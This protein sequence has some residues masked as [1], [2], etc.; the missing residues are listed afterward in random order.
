M[1]DTEDQDQKTELPT[2]RKLEKAIEQGDVAKSQEVTSFF[3]LGAAIIAVSMSMPSTLTSLTMRM[4][5]LI[6]NSHAISIN[7]GG[8]KA[9]A[10]FSLGTIAIVLMVPFL[11]GMLAGIAG[12]MIQ[13]RPVLSSKGLM[14]KLSR[15]SPQSGF[16]RMFGKEAL[17]NFVKGLVKILL[18]GGVVASILWPYRGYFE[19]FVQSDPALT[20]PASYAMIHKILIIVLA[21]MFVIAAADYLYQ[22]HSWMQ[23]QMMT[24][25][26]IKEEYKEQEGNPEIKQK[27]AQMRRQMS[28][29]RMMS[30]VPKASVVV[31]NPTHY[32]VA[33]QYESGM[34]APICVAKGMDELALRIKAVALENDVPVVENPPLARALHAA[35]DLDEAIPE[36]HFKAVAE[37]IGYVMRLKGKRRF[38]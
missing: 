22:R 26:E 7:A 33:L 3:I 1:A 36:E 20:L 5:G 9:V 24:K 31:M 4:R 16:K 8:L 32:A 35:I 38:N 14:P 17:V 15:I 2:Q 23:R 25:H 34:D 10:W 18:V 29:R 37:V 27:L 11:F 13:H 28:Q 19:G 12:N 21:F 30:K 6:D